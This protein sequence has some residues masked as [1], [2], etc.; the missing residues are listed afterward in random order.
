MMWR[1]TLPIAMR[2]R[3]DNCSAKYAVMESPISK[4]APIPNGDASVV[5]CMRSPRRI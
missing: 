3:G 2:S 4:T 1:V 5:I